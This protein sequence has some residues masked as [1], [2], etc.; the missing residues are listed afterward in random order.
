MK[1]SLCWMLLLLMVPAVAAAEPKITVTR[2][3]PAVATRLFDP[4]N[5]P[6]D[7]PELK[8]GEAALCAYNLGAAASVE[9]SMTERSDGSACTIELTAVSVTLTCDIVLWLP[10]GYSRKIRAHEQ[11]HQ[12][13]T[14]RVYATADGYAS[15]IARAA[16][17]RPIQSR[18]GHCRDDADRAMNELTRAITTGWTERIAGKAGRVNDHFDQLT[19]H[20]RNRL[21]EDKAIEQAFEKDK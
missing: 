13:I 3:E 17:A 14:E 10:E 8:Q 19:D 12:A 20:G 11:G 16:A 5:R 4:K 7:M 18:P 2:R 9:V 21:D 1:R 15:E 6:A